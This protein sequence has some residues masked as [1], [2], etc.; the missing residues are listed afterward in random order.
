MKKLCILVP[1]YNE[2]KNI[3]YFLKNLNPIVEKISNRYD[4]KI[5]FSDNN[6][7]D[8]T[9]NLIKIASE[10]D[11]RISFIKLSRNFG[12]QGSLLALLNNSEADCYVIIDVDCEDPPSLILEFLAKYEIGYQYVFGERKWR[13]EIFV[14][15]FM[16]KIFY[17]FT[18][19]IAD[20]EF[21]VD[22]AEFS[23]FSHK[24]KKAALHNNNTY[25]FLRSELAY[26]GFKKIG[27]K[28][29]RNERKL[30]VTNYNI[31]G[32]IKFAIGG[33]LSTSTF[34]LRINI[35]FGVVLFFCGAIFQVIDNN[36]F[37][38]RAFTILTFLYLIFCMMSISIYLARGY[39]NGFA[40]PIYIIEESSNNISLQK[41]LL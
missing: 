31:W 6:S 16:R 13:K 4:I 3:N 40:R 37:N 22:V 10:D 15:T 17:R 24:V 7:S 26:V 35:Y 19:L 1:V 27:I 32:M 14:I 34:P 28:Y 33:I 36:I 21:H 18:K 9:L 41:E 11:K 38:L 23:L 5:I 39:K 20:S 25:P 29:K 30:G 8:N 12:Y 2:E